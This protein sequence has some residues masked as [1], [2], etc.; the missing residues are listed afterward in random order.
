MPAALLISS[1]AG[2]CLTAQPCC[3]CYWRCVPFQ[4]R[5]AAVEALLSRGASV[6]VADSNGDTPL[7]RLVEGWRPDREAQYLSTAK[8]LLAAG[9]DPWLRNRSG[10]AAAALASSRG[11]AGFQSAVAAAAA[12]LGTHRSLPPVEEQE[13]RG[14]ALGN[15]P[16]E[17]VPAAVAR[18]VGA[19]VLLP[20]ETFV[21]RPRGDGGGLR[22]RGGG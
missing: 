5:A 1:S 15:Q 12:V 20:G 14:E 9:A 17:E 22:A 4:G 8:V 2:S 3:N 7:H 6:W 21:N 16:A 18:R 19:A 11:L 13:G 10:V